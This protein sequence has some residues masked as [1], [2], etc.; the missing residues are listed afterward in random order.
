MS[1]PRE[2]PASRLV[3]NL[4]NEVRAESKSLGR[5]TGASV[6]LLMPKQV[7]IRA[8]INFEK[9]APEAKVLRLLEIGCVSEPEYKQFAVQFRDIPVN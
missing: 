8:S 2:T 7:P 3:D 4:G 5:S 1:R 9:V 6:V